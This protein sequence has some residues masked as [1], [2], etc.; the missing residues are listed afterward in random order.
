MSKKIFPLLVLMMSLNA[1]SQQVMTPELLFKLGR[2]SALGITNPDASGQKNILYKV[3]TV[4][5]EENK[6]S[7]KVYIMPV[8]GG[9]AT[10]ITDYTSL[11]KDKGFSSDGKLYV[12]NEEVKIAKVLGKD[13]YPELE[14]SDVQIYDALD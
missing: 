1:F 14:K 10:E 9:N 4:S 8:N 13:F 12:Y 6:S 11:L 5:V 3:T 2:V 7:S